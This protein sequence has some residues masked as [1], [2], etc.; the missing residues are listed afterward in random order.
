MSVKV[1]DKVYLIAHA[2]FHF[3]G[4]VSEILGVRRVSLL[5]ASRI[6]SCS[7]SWELFFRD[8][9]KDDTRSDY[10]GTVKDVSYITA[11]EWKHAL[12]EPK[13]GR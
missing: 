7:R 11:E 5:N 9:C 6:H 13:K 3:L 10:V 12:P 4:E 2:Y 1:G 8:G